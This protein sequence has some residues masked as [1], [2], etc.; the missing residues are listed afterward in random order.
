MLYSE[1]TYAERTHSAEDIKEPQINAKTEL[2]S[3]YLRDNPCAPPVL[4]APCLAKPSK[5]NPPQSTPGSCAG[6]GVAAD[7]CVPRGTLGTSLCAKKSVCEENL[8]TA[9]QRKTDET[10]CYLDDNASL[11]RRASSLLKD[12]ACPI[13]VR[14][15]SN[16]E[17]RR[18]AGEHQAKSCSKRLEATPKKTARLRTLFRHGPGRSEIFVGCEQ[19]PR[20]AGY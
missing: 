4:P 9:D 11:P 1:E 7:K 13:P 8:G 18:V 19:D 16:R 20:G 17:S 6:D 14:S 3:R 5:H 12:V 2:A 10:G 15:P